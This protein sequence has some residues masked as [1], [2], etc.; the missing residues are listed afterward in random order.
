MTDFT[1]EIT[2]QTAR[3]GGKGGQNVNKVETM[4]MGYWNI[5]ATQMF[6]EE[7]KARIFEKL[8]NKINKEG[9]LMVKSQEAR[10][11]LENKEH[12]REKMLQQVH[13]A[14]LQKKKRKPTALSKAAKQ[15]RADDKK[16]AS[17][18][19]AARKGDS[20]EM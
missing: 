12:V 18:K 1:R 16:M 10:S 13:N 4:V 5:A 7:E 20:W 3:S 17:Q 9:L 19:K 8:A 15:R 6:D 11:Q 14:L 2:Y